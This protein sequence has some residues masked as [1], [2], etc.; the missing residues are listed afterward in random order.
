MKQ[1]T[2]FQGYMQITMGEDTTDWKKSLTK[3][4]G[5]VAIA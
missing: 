3:Y 2:L 4:S 1:S 5:C